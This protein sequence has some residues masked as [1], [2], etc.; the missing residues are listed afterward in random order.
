MNNAQPNEQGQAQT[1]TTPRGHE[2]QSTDDHIFRQRIE[3][4]IRDAEEFRLKK[5]NEYRQREFLSMTMSL[6]SVVI[7]A[8]GFAWFFLVQ[9]NLWLAL[10]C[11]LIAVVP[12]VFLTGWVRQPVIQYKNNYKT[13]FMPRLAEALGGLQYF[14]NRGISRKIL[15]RTG[16]VPAHDKYMAEDC[17]S[18][19]YKGAK[20]TFSE[21]RLSSKKNPKDLVFD[22]VF[23]LIEAQHKIFKGHSIITGDGELAKRLTRKLSLLPPAENS[24][25]ARTFSILTNQDS[26]API[27]QD[28][29]LLKELAETAALFQDAK[30]S[31]AFFAG[32]YIFLS[33]PTAHDMFEASDVYVPITTNES[34]VRCKREI[35]QI[36]SIIDLVG[37]IESEKPVS[38]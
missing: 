20:I 22:G 19:H 36:L 34:A 26:N 21:A 3:D 32:N 6:S 9:G 27:L 13:A 18:G 10:L 29:K 7:G 4:L 12:S 31:A 35:D 17:F 38:S 25:F 23:V 8:T 33:V 24:V 1:G 37:V 15:A 14:P 28:D 5:M 2:I 30:L 11:M 16:I